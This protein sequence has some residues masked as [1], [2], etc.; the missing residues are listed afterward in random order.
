MACSLSYTITF[1]NA[2]LSSLKRRRDAMAFFLWKIYHPKEIYNGRIKDKRLLISI[3]IYRKCRIYNGRSNK[4]SY[5]QSFG[6]LTNP[7]FYRVNVKKT[8]LKCIFM[9]LQIPMYI[10]LNKNFLFHS[11]IIMHE[12]YTMWSDKII[13]VFKKHPT[14]FLCKVLFSFFSAIPWYFQTKVRD[15]KN[16]V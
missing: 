7:A 12:W 11:D 5:Y 1:K 4:C 2:K 3:L 16:Q 14:V 15:K 10:H 9:F 6:I 13:Y 8:K